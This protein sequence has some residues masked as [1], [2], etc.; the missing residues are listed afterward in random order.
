MSNDTAT[1]GQ[2]GDYLGGVLNPIFGLAGLIALLWT[3]GRQSLELH[4]ST[5]ELR[6]SAEALRAQ[7]ESLKKQG[8][9]NAFFQL[10]RLQNDIV[11]GIDIRR[12]TADAEGLTVGRDCFR[13]FYS[14]FKM[15]FQARSGA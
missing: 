15:R 9:E 2:F 5:K 1:W 12:N 4:Q 10:L 3:I 14:S 8:F 6:H 11:N 7:N 13:D